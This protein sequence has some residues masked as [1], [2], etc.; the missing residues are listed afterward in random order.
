MG[1]V[2]LQVLKMEEGLLTAA[3]ITEMGFPLPKEWGSSGRMKWGS[4]IPEETIPPL[5]LT[6]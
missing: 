5:S 6:Q 3:K 4:L 2:T 1:D